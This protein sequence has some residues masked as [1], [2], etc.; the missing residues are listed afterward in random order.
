MLAGG[1]VNESVRCS[2]RLGGVYLR[3][4]WGRGGEEGDKEGD[5]MNREGKCERQ[6][7]KVVGKTRR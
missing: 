6:K 4:G 2:E 5:R 7:G 1:L 3:I